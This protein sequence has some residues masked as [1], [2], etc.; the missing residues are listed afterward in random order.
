MHTWLASFYRQG[1][2]MFAVTLFFSKLV[3]Y[4]F[5]DWLPF[6][7]KNTA[8][9]GVYYD[10]SHAAFL[11]TLFDVGGIGGQRSHDLLLIANHLNTGSIA[12]GF[13]L[14]RTHAPAFVCMMFLALSVFT[15]SIISQPATIC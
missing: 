10:T 11:A 3:S 1:V 4:T 5:M 9:G 7:I 2:A 13:L 12:A 14:D 6:Y 8:I 15:V